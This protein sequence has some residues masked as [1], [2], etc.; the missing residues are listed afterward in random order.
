MI[1]FPD[2]K[3]RS[4]AFTLIELLIVVA[5]IAI[6]AAIA[7]PNFLEAQIRAKV[8]RVKA[9]QRTLATAIE[10]YTVDHNK[11]MPCFNGPFTPPWE[12]GSP[13]ARG[14]RVEKRSDRFHWLT[15]PIS[16]ITSI[17][18]DPFVTTSAGANPEANIQIIWSPPVWTLGRLPGSQVGV[19]VA[20]IYFREQSWKDTARDEKS[21]WVVTSAGPDRDYDVLD[22]HRNAVGIQDYDPTNGSVSDG[23][24]L[25]ARQ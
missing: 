25:R 3:V 10:S 4:S 11:P 18:Y 5:I 7:V 14:T 22:S 6:L 1:H 8:S 16:Y 19:N 17:M 15:T 23:D 24:V 13:S 9:D 2:R 21:F 12:S 20:P